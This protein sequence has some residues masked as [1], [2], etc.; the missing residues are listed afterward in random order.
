MKIL[1]TIFIFIFQIWDSGPETKSLS[2]QVKDL[3]VVITN[4]MKE[5]GKAPIA[6]LISGDGGWYK[7][8]QTIAD[9]LAKSGI[10]TLGLDCRKYFWNRKTPDGTA[11]DMEN[12]LNHYSNEWG[13]ENFLLIGYSQGAEIIPFIVTRLPE[14]M[15]RRISSAILLSPAS[16]T[17]FEIHLSNMLG[18]G[19]RHNNYKVIDEINSMKGVPVLIIFGNN[20]KTELPGFFTGTDVRIKKIPGDHHYESNVSLIVRTMKDNKA[21]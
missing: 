3:P 10:P 7:F 8:E 12:L 21:F 17:D 9:T 11:A 4:A 1:C 16:T 15:K 5:I 6:L 13:K 14:A 20:E 2:Y 18:V 19:N